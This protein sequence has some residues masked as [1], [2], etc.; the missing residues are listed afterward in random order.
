M[1]Y[2]A[3][4]MALNT[5]TMCLTHTLYHF[6]YHP[7]TDRLIFMDDNA[8]PHRARVVREFNMNPIKHVWE[9]ISRKVNQCNP[10]CQNIAELINTILEEWRRFQQERLRHLVHGMNR[11]MQELWCKHGGY[12]CYWVKVHDN[13][14]PK[15]LNKLWLVHFLE[16]LT[17]NNPF[18]HL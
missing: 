7:L 3:T 4:S 10:Q 17:K 16:S 2:K 12:T 5:A 11:R 15:V 9:F 13:A 6:D 1:S 8:R 14:S 18:F